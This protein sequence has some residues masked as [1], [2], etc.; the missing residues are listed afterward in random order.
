MTTS[1][2]TN[3]SAR[4]AARRS[5]L[6]VFIRDD[7]P[8]VVKM[9]AELQDLNDGKMGAV[10]E[11]GS[12]RREFARQAIKINNRWTYGGWVEKTEGREASVETLAYTAPSSVVA[13]GAVVRGK[14]TRIMGYSLITGKG[15][16]VSWS[17]IVFDSTI[18]EGAKASGVGTMIVDSEL[19]EAA[20]V[21]TGG[22]V[23][24]S[25]ISGSNTVVSD[26][27]MVFLSEVS[28]GAKVS[29][30]GTELSNSKLFGRKAKVFK[31]ARVDDCEIHGLRIGGKGTVVT[32]VNLPAGI[33]IRIE[34]GAN[35]DGSKGLN[36]LIV[37]KATAA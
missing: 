10:L 11:D 8:A 36:T 27:G 23:G 24:R 21:T 31:G 3:Q 5:G 25:R 1:V 12:G 35:I 7:K 22:Q 19:S 18:K 17:A 15:T 14:N 37:A 29:G 13:D 34:E 33:S 4:Y 28:D 30:R 16:K 32:R 26:E 2:I 20:Q 9:I 6:S